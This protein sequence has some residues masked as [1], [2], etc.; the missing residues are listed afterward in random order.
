MS[1]TATAQPRTAIRLSSQARLAAAALALL[2]A[3]AI[4]LVLALGG[5]SADDSA[6]PNVGAAPALRS[7]G[8]PSESSVAVSVSG[9][10]PVVAP[11]EARVA[12][13]VG[14]R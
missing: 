6:T 5:T 12:A 2:A 10:T 8:G 1:Q 7:D 11:D 3:V 14:G 9:G 4:T 13:A